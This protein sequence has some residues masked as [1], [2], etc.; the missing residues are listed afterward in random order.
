MFDQSYGLR[1]DI[2]ERVHLSDEVVG[3]QELEEIELVPNVQVVPHG[4]HATLRGNLLLSGVYK[5]D[6]EQRSTLTLTHFIPVEITL[7]MNRVQSLDDISVEIENF[8]VDLLSTRTINI[9]GVLS[10]KGI[11]LTQPEQS[12]WMAEQFTVVHQTEPAKVQ[13]GAPNDFR[14]QSNE[15]ENDD[16]AIQASKNNDALDILESVS[17]YEREQQIERELEQKQQQQQQ[18]HIEFHPE[19]ITVQ[20]EVDPRSEIPQEAVVTAERI[21][22]ASPSEPFQQIDSL[23]TDKEPQLDFTQEEPIEQEKVFISSADNAVEESSQEPFFDYGFVEEQPAPDV[24]ELSVE[25]RIAEEKKELK[26]AF[27]SK[28]DPEPENV[29]NMGLSALLYSSKNIKEIETRHAV[30]ELEKQAKK[31]RSDSNGEEVEWKSLFLNHEDEK[32]A[33]RKL[34]ICIVQREETLDVIADRYNMNPRELLLYNRLNDHTI[35]EGQ[36]LYIP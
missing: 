30:E 26:V 31:L 23:E 35:A 32:R 22:G 33:F 21:A 4:D 24:E 12:P 5:G 34:K 7:P 13:A 27:N 29:G 18:Q 28:K 17:L 19:V 36:V 10:L 3:I 14:S 20:P 25:E 6:D 9:N 15:E 11:E 16:E 2:Y 1:F 8:D